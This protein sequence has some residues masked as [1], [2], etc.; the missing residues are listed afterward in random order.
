[1][2][3]VFSSGFSDDMAREQLSAVRS[4]QDRYVQRERVIW[5]DTEP[6]TECTTAYS[7]T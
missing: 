7:R 3:I 6:V 2:F 4:Q 5:S 1:M